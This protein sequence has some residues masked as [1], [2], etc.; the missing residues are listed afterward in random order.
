HRARL[1]FLVSAAKGSQETWEQQFE[2]NPD[3]R[4][5]GWWIDDVSIDETLGSPAQLVNDD[6]ALGTCSTSGAPCVGQCEF[7]LNSCDGDFDCG[8]G[9]SCVA[10]CPVGQDCTGPPEDCGPTCSAVTANVFVEPA[11]ALNPSTVDV[12]A[13][14]WPVSFNAAADDPDAGAVPSEADACHDGTLQ[15]RFCFSADPDS[16]CDDPLDEILR[17]WTENAFLPLA[18][19]VS[20]N[21]VVEA[22]CSSDPLCRDARQIRIGVACPGED[23]NVLSLVQ[24]R[25]VDKNTLSWFGDPLDI[26]V[27]SS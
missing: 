16:D 23:A 24:I 7:A 11:G 3:A 26:D 4:D 8:P 1:R 25:A 14:R 5:D 2:I 19:R 12:P 22:R 15:F 27:W 9:E 18:P 20:G 13:P 10:P 6:F 21:Y 17:G